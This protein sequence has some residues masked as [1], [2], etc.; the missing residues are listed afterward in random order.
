MK[1]LR[2]YLLILIF[3]GS[4]ILPSLSEAAT[5]RAVLMGDTNDRLGYLIEKGLR[6]MEQ[7]M[8]TI[9]AYADLDLDITYV[10]GKDFSSQNI[11]NTLQNLEVDED[12]LVFLYSFSHGYREKQ[13]ATPWPSIHIP[14]DDSW[15]GEGIDQL[16]LTE[17]LQEKNPKL[18]ISMVSC[19]NSYTDDWCK[20]KRIERSTRFIL[21]NPELVKQ[22]YR[23]LFTECKGTIIISSSTPGKYSAVDADCGEYTLSAFLHTLRRKSQSET[24]SW[25]SLIEMT[26]DKTWQST[27]WMQEDQYRPQAE[28]INFVEY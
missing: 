3:I 15:T 6:E 26:K 7:E 25:Q 1:A 22:N 12:D 23:H 5:L 13:T 21:R 20:P 9:A 18:L 2:K 8:H 17:I 10:Q 14:S 4:F 24:L 11:L 16:V 28:F 27:K 19:C